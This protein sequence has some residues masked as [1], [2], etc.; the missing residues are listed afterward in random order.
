MLNSNLYYVHH[1]HVSVV[2]ELVTV[3]EQV[4]TLANIGP[5]DGLT[6]S[7]RRNHQSPGSS[8]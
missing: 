4:R 3:V 5:A 6:E 2:L 1:E 7:S 8:A